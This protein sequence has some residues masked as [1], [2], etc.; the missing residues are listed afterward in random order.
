MPIYPSWRLP[1]CQATSHLRLRFK[2]HLH[3][4]KANVI[5]NFSFIG[6]GVSMNNKLNSL[7]TYLRLHFCFNVNEPLDL[8]SLVLYVILKF[9][10]TPIESEYCYTILQSEGYSQQVVKPITN[11][12]PIAHYTGTCTWSPTFTKTSKHRKTTLSLHREKTLTVIL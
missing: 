1:S 10:C 2:V 12:K 5:A 6:V 3:S 11:N 9:Y 4:A 8:L 7:W